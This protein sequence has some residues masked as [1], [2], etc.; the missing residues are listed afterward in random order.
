MGVLQVKMFLIAGLNMCAA[1]GSAL[2]INKPWNC[3]AEGFHN[4]RCV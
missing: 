4:C 1:A 2:G 3:S